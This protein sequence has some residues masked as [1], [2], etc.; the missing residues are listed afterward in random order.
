M[1]TKMAK[2]KKQPK[3]NKKTVERNVLLYAVLVVVFLSLA[4]I[5]G[6]LVYNSKQQVIQ[7][8]DNAIYSCYP[9]DFVIIEESYI[10]TDDPLNRGT[11][12]E[13]Y[14]KCAINGGGCLAGFKYKTDKLDSDIIVRAD[15]GAT[16]EG[17]NIDD[18]T[19]KFD[20]NGRLI[21]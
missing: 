6:T 14:A 17:Y 2:S 1:E 21:N 18:L 10:S 19:T 20:E 4:A 15:A 9:R 12:L 11:D 7:P 16:C 13:P 3:T 5:F 8:L